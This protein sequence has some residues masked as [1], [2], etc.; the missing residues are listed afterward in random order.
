MEGLPVTTGVMERAMGI[1]QNTHNPHFGW[2]NPVRTTQ[3]LQIARLSSKRDYFRMAR[4]TAS[5]LSRRAD[6]RNQSLRNGSKNSQESE[7]LQFAG[8]F[9][10]SDF[11][12]VRF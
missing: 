9:E 6:R 3:L 12:R 2:N 4:D 5:E 11:E 10:E 7:L 1:E 8:H